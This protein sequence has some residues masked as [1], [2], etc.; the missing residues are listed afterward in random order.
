MPTTITEADLAY[1]IRHIERQTGLALTR[2]QMRGVWLRSRL[3]GIIQEI[4]RV[5]AYVCVDLADSLCRELTGGNWPVEG[6]VGQDGLFFHD[7]SAAAIE[8]GYSVTTRR[9]A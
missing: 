2:E 6:D 9:A 8:A 5:D 3:A 1:A 4:G 7:F